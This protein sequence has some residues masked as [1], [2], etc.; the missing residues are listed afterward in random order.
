MV[1]YHITIKGKQPKQI[2]GS[3]MTELTILAKR[4]Q[5][6]QEWNLEDIKELISHAG[7]EDEWNA[8][9]AEDAESIIYKAADILGVE[10]LS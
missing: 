4:I 1:W 9:D 3:Q 6:S 5:Q 2:G 7:L 8:A 10:V